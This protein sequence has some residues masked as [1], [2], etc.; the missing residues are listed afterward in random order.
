MEKRQKNNQQPRS[1]EN[2]V[3]MKILE[4]VVLHEEKIPLQSFYHGIL[5][6]PIL[7]VAVDYPG[8]FA[9]QWWKI[10]FVHVAVSARFTS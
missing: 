1:G 9:A 10:I 2:F 8:S 7:Y 5:I 3:V 6:A 4:D